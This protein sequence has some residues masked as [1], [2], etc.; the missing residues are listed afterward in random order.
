MD[1]KLDNKGLKQANTPQS[2]EPKLSVDEAG[3]KRRSVVL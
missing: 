2:E 3:G 1:F